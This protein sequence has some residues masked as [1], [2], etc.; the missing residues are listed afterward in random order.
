MELDVF[1][2][3]VE[4]CPGS[5]R[6]KHCNTS[7]LDTG[8]FPRRS[9]ADSVWQVIFKPSEK[10]PL[11][12]LALAPL[13]AE[14]G[15][16]P[17][18]VQFVTGA[19]QTGSLLASHMDIAKISFTGSIAVGKSVQEAATRSNLK[20]VTLEL[21]GKSAALVFS[22]ADFKVA[23]D[24]YVSLYRQPSHILTA[25]VM[26]SVARGFLVNSGQICVGKLPEA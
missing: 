11:G 19:Q 24:R 18:V 4:A 16:P 15:F 17:G 3:R 20:R 23:V 6:G 9:S 21:G 14:A 2:H 12:S 10:S 22:D 1:I 13:Y 7:L 25:P 26:C 5:C 8:I